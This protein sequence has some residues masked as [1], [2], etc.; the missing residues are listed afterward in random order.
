MAVP[1]APSK[2]GGRRSTPRVLG[3]RD[4][5]DVGR[6]GARS[7][8]TEVV[9]LHPLRDGPALHLVHEPVHI[10]STAEVSDGAVTVVSETASPQ[11]A[12][13][14]RSLI[15]ALCQAVPDR[16]CG[17]RVA[18]YDDGRAGAP[19]SRVVLAAP[20]TS[21]L[22]VAAASNGARLLLGDEEPEVV[23]ANEANGLPLDVAV[24]AVA[25]LRERRGL[26]APAFTGLRHDESL[27]LREE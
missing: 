17:R 19:P 24:L 23:S 15:E 27:G 11:P 2:V 26:A 18:S 25:L 1:A 8:P 20:A 9:Q 16:E 5:L 22:L 6:V 13:A 7:V 12:A 14:R 3:R 21:V 10:S 4:W